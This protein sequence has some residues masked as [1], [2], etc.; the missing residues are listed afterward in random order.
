LSRRGGV[1]FKLSVT[2]A[3][4]ISGLSHG[5]LVEL[6]VKLLGR[7]ADLERI[8]AEQR[9]E[10]ARLKGLPGRPD[11]KPSGMEKAA[12]AKP[13]RRGKRRRRGKSAPRVSVEERIVKA[14]APAGSR[15]KGYENYVVQELVLRAQVIRY[16]R[17]RWVTPEG[18]TI[19]AALPFDV[20]GHFGAELRRFVLL[21]HHQ[22]QVRW[23]GSPRSCARWVSASPSAKWYGC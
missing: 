10:I 2:V 5:E 18:R 8:V 14:A 23:S 4:E 20:S 1:R 21:Q 11:I 15:F 3:P 22:G 9:D 13:A 7:V 12:M 17:E 6:V 16:R 19:L